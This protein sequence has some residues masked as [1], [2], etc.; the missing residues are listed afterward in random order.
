MLPWIGRSDRANW[1]R[2][3]D[4]SRSAGDTPASLRIRKRRVEEARAADSSGA[5]ARE[6]RGLPGHAKLT[7]SH[8]DCLKRLLK[9]AARI[10]PEQATAAFIAGVGGSTLLGRQV[11]VSYA[12]ARHLPAHKADPT[13]GYKNCRTC[14]I[15]LKEQ[16]DPTDRIL[17]VA[18]G[19]VWNEGAG[20]YFLDLEEY[21]RGAAPKPTKA[22]REVLC[23]VLRTAAKVAPSCTPGELEKE[24]AAKKVIPSSEKYARY[25]IL[26]A[27][28]MVGVLP[29]PFLPPEWDHLVERRKS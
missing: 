7:I 3:A 24:L 15:D 23:A 17:R 9:A 28:A 16:L 4:V 14:G 27:L 5:R 1:V 18:L 6:A 22:D 12:H 10:K 21:L 11:L 2:S 26:E 29:N 13:P 8:D 19:N 25:G 20:N